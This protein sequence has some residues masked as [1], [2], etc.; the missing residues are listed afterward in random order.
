MPNILPSTLLYKCIFKL[1]ISLGGALF[2]FSKLIKRSSP[3]G[4]SYFSLSYK[5]FNG[6]DNKFTDLFINCSNFE[7]I[8]VVD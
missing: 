7:F 3:S 2:D 1:L 8:S 5:P 4:Y 6:F